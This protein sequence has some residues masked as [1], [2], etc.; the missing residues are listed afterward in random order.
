MYDLGVS[1]GNERKQALSGRSRQLF[2]FCNAYYNFILERPKLLG[3][4]FIPYENERS[5]QIVN[6]GYENYFSLDVGEWAAAVR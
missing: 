6:C 1:W 3:F 5:K 4:G 2:D